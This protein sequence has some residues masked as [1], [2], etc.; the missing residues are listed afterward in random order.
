[1]VEIVGGSSQPA[2]KRWRHRIRSLSAGVFTLSPAAARNMATAQRQ[3][4]SQVFVATILLPVGLLL[5]ASP[6][7]SHHSWSTYHWARTS[8]PFTLKLGDNVDDKWDG[9]LRKAAGPVDGNDWS[10]S[11]VLDAEV[12]SGGTRPKNC[13]PTSG[14]VEVCN[15]RYGNT[16]WLGLA[17]IWITDSH[18]TQGVVKLNDT[19][20]LMTKYNTPAW[21]ALGVCHEVGHTFGLDHQDEIFNNDNLGS[22][23]DY[24]DDPD[25]TPGSSNDPSNER[26]NE[27]DY[28]QLELIYDPELEGGVGHLDESTTLAA[29]AR[30]TPSRRDGGNSPADWGRPVDFTADG[31][32]HI[33]LKRLG[34]RTWLQ[35]HVTWIE[36]RP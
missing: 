6:A 33:Y 30:A 29:A 3:A 14:R 10:D 21:R 20:F 34:P 36:G 25:G 18:I 22:C 31:K 27:H 13:R 1:M 17:Q 4:W 24:T 19:Y 32:P 8:N 9:Y 15:A 23:L 7:L 5:T 2:A 16:G 11:A 26:P 12:I 35:T 28:V